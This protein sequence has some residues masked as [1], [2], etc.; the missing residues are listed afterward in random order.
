MFPGGSLATRLLIGLLVIT[1]LGLLVSGV[2]GFLT[3]R[4]FITDRLDSEVEFTAERAQTRMEVGTP[5][6]GQEAPTP[7]RYFVVVLDPE[8]GEVLHYWGD[9]PREDVVLERIDDIT[10]ETLR[11]Y[12][13]TQ[14][15]FDLEGVTETVPSQRA[16]VRLSPDWI[17]V[18]GVPTDEREIYP[19]RLV[20]SQLIT[21]GVLVLGL[22]LGGRWLMVR[23]LAPLDRMATRASEISSGPDLGARMPQT[24]SR[25]EVG[26]L[27][28]AINTMLGRIEEAFQRQRE[29]E[30]RIRTF[31]ADA[32]HELRTPLTTI[33]GYA[34]LYGQ[35]AIPD[36]ELPGAMG[37]I[38]DEAERMSQL[39]AELLELARLDRGEVLTLSLQDLADITREMAADADAVEPDRPFTVATP[40]RLSWLIDEARFRQVLA[41]LLANV[42][43]HT[44]AG[45]PATIRL[46]ED[47]EAGVVRLEVE[48]DGPGMSLDDQHRAFDRFYRGQRAPGGGSGLGLAI[49]HAIATAHG[50]EVLIDSSPD[51][52][53][54]VQVSF[55]ASVAPSTR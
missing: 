14:E 48:D 22:A 26:R 23:G 18:S 5:P 43:E 41:N 49:V 36:R 1:G 16:T 3:L 35:G 27:G 21:A 8:D 17:M 45:T 53:T 54:T 52:G 38:H 50:G 20:S 13:I 46:V 33:R 37:R 29:S 11:S 34:E 9:T 28:L 51:G 10:V 6:A 15:V 25:T 30:E 7:S 32:S 4:G 44:P 2:V 19:L 40:D 42:R 47:E 55:P 12:G 31:A 39:V 24:N